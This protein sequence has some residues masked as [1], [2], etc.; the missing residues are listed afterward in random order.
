MNRSKVVRT[1]EGGRRTAFPLRELTAFAMYGAMMY[2]SKLVLEFLPNVHLLGTLTMVAAI[3]WRKRALIPIYVYVFLN[4][5]FAG[6]SF[7]WLPYLYIWT[8][9]WGVTM[10][11]PK[12]MPHRVAAVVYP[13]VCAGH[14]FLFGILYAPAQALVFNLS[15]EGMLA[16]IAAGLPFDLIH[17]VA[18]FA[19]GLLVL[20]LS[21]LVKKLT[22]KTA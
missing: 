18:N 7:W 12:K 6:F 22:E 17:G 8:L 13:I 21:D 5:L 19:A 10:L 4:G 11:L 15:F 1:R 16:W 9:L 20:P 3:V 2:I 14:G